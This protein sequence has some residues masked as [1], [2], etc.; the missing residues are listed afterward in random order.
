MKYTCLFPGFGSAPPPPPPP[1]PAP[2]P[3]PP[4]PP[5]APE[6]KRFDK[7][8]ASKQILSARAGRRGATLDSNRQG[9]LGRI[10]RPGA[11]A[12]NEKLG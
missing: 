4:P 9:G 1:P 12:T 11:G 3:P 2:P 7:Q 8:E 6:G 5:P 10:S